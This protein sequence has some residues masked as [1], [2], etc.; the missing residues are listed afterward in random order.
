MSSSSCRCAFAARSPPWSAMK[1]TAGWNQ[2]VGETIIYGS[3]HKSAKTATDAL[4]VESKKARTAFQRI[5]VSFAPPV[6]SKPQQ[7][8]KLSPIIF[9]HRLFA[10]RGTHG[11]LHSGPRNKRRRLFPAISSALHLHGTRIKFRKSSADETTCIASRLSGILIAIASKS[12]MNPAAHAL[13]NR[14]FAQRP[15]SVRA[16]ATLIHCAA[17]ATTMASVMPVGSQASRT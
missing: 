1:K 10:F 5:I 7:L 16:I 13:A 15:A 11:S 17:T 3:H 2:I 8:K 14:C 6:T 9:R 12:I 4:L